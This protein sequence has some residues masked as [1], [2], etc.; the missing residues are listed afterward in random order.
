MMYDDKQ[1]AA[2][3]SVKQAQF[4]QRPGFEVDARL[5]AVC[6]PQISL[7]AS[8]SSER[9]ASKIEPADRDPAFPVRPH[10]SLLNIVLSAS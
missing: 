1:V 9:S 10:H 7:T 4:H 5:N 2:T 6:D 3:G 8:P